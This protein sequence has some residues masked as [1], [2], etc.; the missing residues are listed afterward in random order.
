MLV[1]SQGVVVC[2]EGDVA[3][4]VNL[5]VVRPTEV[6]DCDPYHGLQQFST[7]TLYKRYS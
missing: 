4:D 3:I 7:Q 2:L 1:R 5:S 6:G